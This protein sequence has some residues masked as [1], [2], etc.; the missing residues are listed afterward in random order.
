MKMSHREETSSLMKASTYREHVNLSLELS[1]MVRILIG[2]VLQLNSEMLQF[3]LFEAQVPLHAL[4]L[5]LE[6]LDL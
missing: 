2:Q 1:D 5:T 3:N 4:Q 6:A